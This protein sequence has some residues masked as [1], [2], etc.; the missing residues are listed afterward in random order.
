MD[1]IRFRKSPLNR[2][3][4][5]PAP[6]PRKPQ[7]H[8][9]KFAQ[10]AV[11][12]RLPLRPVADH[13]AVP[14]QNHPRDFR[15]DLAGV[16]GHEGQRR[17]ARSDPAQ[18][19]QKFQPRR[20]IKRGRWLVEHQRLRTVDERAGDQESPFFSRGKVP[21]LPPRQLR[22]PHVRHR[23]RG[24]CFLGGAETHVPRPPV[25]TPECRDHHICGDL[26]RMEPL[27]LL[28]HH[29]PDPVPQ[30]LKAPQ[31]PA[32]KPDRSPRIRL[33]PQLAGHQ[34]QQAAF[35]RA[36]RAEDRHAL[37]DPQREI[38]PAQRHHIPAPDLGVGGF[39]KRFAHPFFSSLSYSVWCPIQ[40]QTSPSG[41][42]L[43]IA[44]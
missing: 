26:R 1:T 31:L 10:R 22:D 14:E 41:R 38:Q 21:E 18:R 34:F 23:L 4:H 15:Q 24:Q 29:D 13:A 20:E 32:E 43:A 7:P 35:P 5:R 30:L 33:R 8:R 19:L 17:P 39:E 37:P 44:R 9:V 27:H 11:V 16:V 2:P 25:G 12:Q 42:S 40:I 28:R 6:R 36:V 3:D